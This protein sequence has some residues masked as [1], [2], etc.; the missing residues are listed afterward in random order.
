MTHITIREQATDQRNALLIYDYGEQFPIVISDPFTPKE[1]ARLEWYFEEHLR[2]PF[3]RQVRAREAAASVT[4]YGEELFNQVFAD[5][6]AYARYQEALQAGVA[7]LSFEIA[8]SPEFHGY[9]WEALKDPDLPQPLALQGVM[10]R[11]NLVPQTVRAGVRESPTINL[12]VVTARPGGRRDVGYRTISRPLVEGLRQAGIPVSVDILR[13]GTYEALTDHLE[14]VQDERE[15]GYYHVIH[16]DVHGALLSY[17][18]YERGVEADRFLFQARYGRDDIQPYEGQKA[19]L[20]LESGEPG[21]SDPVEA[22]ELA[23]LLI[24]HQVPI[25]ILNACQSGK[26][27]R[28]DDDDEIEARETSLGSRMM[29]AGVQMVLAMGYSVTV[30]AAQLLMAKLYE[31]LFAGQDLSSAIRRG[32]LELYNRKSRRAYFDQEIDLEDWIL[33]VVYQNQEQKL[34]VREFSAAERAAYYEA[35]ARRYRPPEVTYGF[36]GRDLDILEIERRLLQRNI[37]LLQGMGGVG[38]TTLLHHVA[39]WW[40]TTGFVGR[41]C[42]F[43]YDERAWTRQQIMSEIAKQLMPEAEYIT[44]FQPLSPQAQQELLADRLRADRHLLVLDNLESIT[45]SHLAIKNTLSDDERQRLHSF[46]SDLSGGRSLVLLGSRGPETWLASGTFEDNLYEVPGLD[47]EAA[48]T[49]ADRILERHHATQYR[50]DD[51]LRHLLDLLDGYPLPM[52][53]VLA[54]LAHQTPAEVLAALQ[55]GDEAFDLSSESKTESIL[56]CID[57]SH[58]N[59]SPDAQQLLVCLAPFTG[60]VRQGALENY[61]ACLRQRPALAHLPFERWSEV[62][63]DAADWGLLSPHA[64]VPGVL[65]LQPILPYFLR[66]RLTAEPE[67]KRS[68]ETAFRQLYDSFG[69]EIAHL[70]AFRNAQTRQAGQAFARLEYEN[71]VQAVNLALAAQEPIDA[72]YQALSVYWSAAQEHERALVQSASFLEKLRAYPAEKLHTKRTGFGLLGLL[73]TMGDRRSILRQ[74]AAAEACYLEAARVITEIT[75]VDEEQRARWNAIA[76]HNLGNVA[77]AQREWVQAEAYYQQALEIFIEFDDRD[78]QAGTYQNLGM[79]AQAQREWVQAEAHNQQALEI[80]IEL[81]D[82]YSQAGTYHNLGSVALEQRAWVQAEAYYQQA[83]E[84]YKEFDDRHLQGAT[85]HQLGRVAQEQRAWVQAE[86]YYQQALEVFIGLDDRHSQALTYHNLGR[87]A[88]EQWAWGQAEA[89][90]Q[91]ALEIY[92]EFDD[93]HP[94]G[95]TYHNLGRVAQEQRAWG[96]A[97]AY[98]Q[99]ALEISI[100]FDDRYSQAS[101]YRQLGMVAQAQ[102]AWVQAEAHYKQA[103]EIEIGSDDRYSQAST[104]RQLGTVALEQQQWQAARQ[105]LVKALRIFVDVDDGHSVSTALASLAHLWQ[106]TDDADILTAAAKTLDTDPQEVEQMFRQVLSP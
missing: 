79:M 100:E 24:A 62:V 29:S 42:N 64:D 48:S 43:G 56:R 22:E 86:A 80:L 19:F 50:Q 75:D 60:V 85:Y 102:R 16:F 81:D 59:L 2:F 97:E 15:A 23:D 4:R 41:V 91:Q 49:L 44:A 3:T 95:A 73:I 28:P 71:L 63:Q 33:P 6:K 98:Y 65:R 25:V 52:E 77:Q 66:S 45:G 1:E 78:R 7:T 70:V 35:R 67:L 32:R 5:R 61:T 83:L 96:Q 40:Q 54:N 30:S 58:S 90:C 39:A 92:K 10:V 55:K 8:G 9:H 88:Q 17:A 69:A 94:Q 13:P 68:I 105:H 76:Y 84:I 53:V 103:L 12:L 82:R 20:T 27:V 51:D 99:Q 21:R 34:R 72:P 11:R 38:K 18:D 104:Y 101:A 31:Q 87:V 14:T 47:P 89:Y 57:Y 93:R 37:L 74:Y 26:Q 36:V 46:L 106:S